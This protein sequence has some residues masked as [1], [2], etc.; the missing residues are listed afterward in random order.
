MNTIPLYGY[1]RLSI[2]SPIE[3]YLTYLQLLVIMNKTA[4]N[5]RMPRVCVCTEG[6]SAGGEHLAANCWVASAPLCTVIH[7]QWMTVCAA[8]GLCPQLLSGLCNFTYLPVYL[9]HSNGVG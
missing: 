6:F 3:G 1:T 4:I 5:E 8:S 7:Q 2:Y 9:I